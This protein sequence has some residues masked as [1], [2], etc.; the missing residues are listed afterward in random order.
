MKLG[1]LAALTIGL[2]LLTLPATQPRSHPH[3]W[4]DALTFL[5]FEEGRLTHLRVQWAFD[6]FFSAILYE[7][8]DVNRNDRFDPEEIEAMRD[9]A[10][11]GLGQVGFFTDL[12]IDG[13]RVVWNGARDFGI[14]VSEDGSI[15][16]YS[17]T[18]DVDPAPDPLV[19]QVS[20]SV[21][22]PEYY[23]DVAFLQQDPIRI[24]G[25]NGATCR[26]ELVEAEDNPIYFGAVY[27][28]RAEFDCA[29]VSG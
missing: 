18:L 9:G 27:P 3:V 16:A 11:L 6:E 21:Y 5:G 7:D 14:A 19:Q 24:R 23:V 26:Y 15:V 4:V 28:I 1:K 12:R 8:F 2:G 13:E 10:F 17:F 22:D 20:L 25:L 29:E